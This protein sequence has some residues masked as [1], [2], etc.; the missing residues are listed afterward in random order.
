MVLSPQK[1]WES[2]DRSLMPLDVSEIYRGKTAFGEERR[3]YFNGEPSA[4]EIGRA[5]V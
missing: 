2:Y 3:V 4:L 5:H 1:L